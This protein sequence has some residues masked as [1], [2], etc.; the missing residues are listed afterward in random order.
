M[1]RDF[2]ID[3]DGRRSRQWTGTSVTDVAHMNHPIYFGSGSWLFFQA[4]WDPDG[5]RWTV[6]GVG[7]RARRA[8]DDRGLRD[9]CDRIAVRILRESRSSF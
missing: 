2:Q 6:L 9:D 4:Q 8:G 1:M 3:I 7:N 5:Q